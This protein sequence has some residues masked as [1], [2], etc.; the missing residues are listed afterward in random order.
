MLFGAPQS[1]GNFVLGLNMTGLVRGDELTLMDGTEVVASGTSSVAFAAMVDSGGVVAQS[2]Y[3]TGCDNN[4]VWIIQ[5]SNG[6]STPDDPTDPLSTLND[7]GATFQ[8]LSGI[9][10]TGNGVGVDSTGA[11]IWYRFHIVTL[12]GDD[13]PVVRVRRG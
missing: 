7:F 9:G 10:A 1:G 12:V 4:T 6:P 11:S 8:N 3:V 2:F 5:G 13:H